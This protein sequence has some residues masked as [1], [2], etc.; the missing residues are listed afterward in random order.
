[1]SRC[2][3][4]DL[5]AEVSIDATRSRCSVH[6][7]AHICAPRSPSIDQMCIIIRGRTWGPWRGGN[8]W[9]WSRAV[10]GQVEPTPSALQHP[11]SFSILLLL[12]RSLRREQ[13]L[14]RGSSAGRSAGG[15]MREGG[16]EGGWIKESI[17]KERKEQI[18]KQSNKNKRL[19][20]SDPALCQS[21]RVG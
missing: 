18:N 19:R 15:R 7:W 21:V 8:I 9:G 13:A 11:F 12:S 10:A 5:Y 1:M 16:R 20:H 3:D 2:V 6:L 17:K 4:T 14:A